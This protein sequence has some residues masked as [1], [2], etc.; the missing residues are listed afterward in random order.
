V[1]HDDSRGSS[2]ASIGAPAIHT[3]QIARASQ[4]SIGNAPVVLDSSPRSASRA[5]AILFFARRDN[6]WGFSRPAARGEV[7]AS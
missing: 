5:V 7:A 1:L 4:P 6:V 2:V 3:F